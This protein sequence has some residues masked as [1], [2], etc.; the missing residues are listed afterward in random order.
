M[1][2]FEIYFP[3]E[4]IEEGIK[5]ENVPGDSGGATKFGE[6]VDDL[7]KCGLDENGDGVIDW[8]DVRDLT[9]ADA[10]KVLKK[11]YWDLYGADDIPNQ[12]LAMF[13]VDGALNQGIPTITRM[14]QGIQEIKHVQLYYLQMQKICLTNFII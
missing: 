4:N 1:A 12:S 5:F 3:I 10:A 13:I 2:K 9:A 6:V 14:I 7:K 11:I 8:K